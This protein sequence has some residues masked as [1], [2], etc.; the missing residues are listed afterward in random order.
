MSC[1][2]ADSNQ[3][4]HHLK[5]ASSLR[6]Y[7]SKDL[8]QIA[9]KK[10]VSGWHTMRKEQLVQA[11]LKTH[12]RNATAKKTATTAP[13][14]KRKAKPVAE[15]PI[16]K[17]ARKMQR[18]HTRREN[19]KDLALQ[20]AIK[21]SQVPIQEDRIILIVR[22]PFWLQAYWEITKNSVVRA[23]AALAENWHGAT[24]MLRVMKTSDDDRNGAVEEVLREI[25]IHGGVKNW[26]IDVSDPPG[27]FRVQIGYKAA[28]GK[29]HLIARS[30]RVK[31]PP[32]S[33]DHDENW[34]DIAEDYEKYYAQSGGYTN[35]T[36]SGELKS[37]FEE[38]LRRPMHNMDP[39]Y[40][41][42][43]ACSYRP[44]NFEVDAHMVIYGA[45]A[46]GSNV[47]LAGEPVKLEDD[48]TFS[49]RLGMPDR[50]QVLPIVASSR[51]GSEQRTTVLAI[52]RNTKMMEPITRDNEAL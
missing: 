43:S 6:T 18:E 45:T 36:S 49:V 10:G 26:Y 51:D 21:R 11:I 15:K 33:G 30:N 48:G 17:V 22:D 46:P 39:H 4:R 13:T 3:R 40:V 29:F 34:T 25:P 37:V 41:S 1:F 28:N 23:K 9:K 35:D 24:P 52:E 20:S 12:K 44:F 7:T 32:A 47:T 19:M 31:T 5:T 50:R 14:P 2:I 8:A 16:T 27:Q 38:K 42:H